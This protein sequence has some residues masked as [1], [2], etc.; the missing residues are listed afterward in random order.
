MKVFRV[1]LLATLFLAVLLVSS[2]NPTL[3]NSFLASVNYQCLAEENSGIECFCSLIVQGFPHTLD[4]Q[5]VQLF[6]FTFSPALKSSSTLQRRSI[7]RC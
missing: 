6:E 3:P 5:C 1:L 7:L 2:S 4:F